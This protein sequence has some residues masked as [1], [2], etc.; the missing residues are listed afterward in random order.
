MN[1]I[2]LYTSFPGRHVHAD[3][4]LISLGSIQPCTHTHARTHTHTHTLFA[5]ILISNTVYS[6]VINFIQLSELG[7]SG[8]NEN[9]QASKRLQRE[10]EPGLLQLRVWRSTAELSCSTGASRVVQHQR[11]YIELDVSTLFT[12][13]PFVDEWLWMENGKQMRW[14][15]IYTQVRQVYIIYSAASWFYIITINL[16][17]NLYTQSCHY[18]FR[19]FTGSLVIWL[20]PQAG[21]HDE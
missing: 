17:L 9:V 5:H 18:V 19:S 13:L 15:L 16:Y 6:L 12:D 4:N 3:T 11:Q 10:F 8:E 2:A 7:H 1:S 21:I 14:F 20:K